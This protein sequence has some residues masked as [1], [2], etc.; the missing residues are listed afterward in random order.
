MV[1]A[2]DQQPVR[3]VLVGSGNIASGSHLPSLK[4]LEQENIC[5]VVGIADIDKDKAEATAKKFDVPVFGN[6]WRDVVKRSSA[7]AVSV[8]TTPGPN[9]SISTEAVHEN[10]HVLCEKP[11]GRNISDTRLLAEAAFENPSRITMVAFNRRY[12]PL[13]RKVV[14]ASQAIAPPSMFDGRFTRASLGAGPSD[15]LE[16]WIT[17]DGSHTIDMAISIMGMPKRIT[18]W[19]SATG[20]NVDNV[21]DIIFETMTATSHLHFNFAAGKRME[22]F[23]WIGP[24]YDVTL[25]LPLQAIWAERGKPVEVWKAEEL[26][27]VALNAWNYGFGEQ[28]RTFFNAI[29]GDGP[30]PEPNF[31]YADQFMK[32]IDVVLQ[33]SNGES[34]FFEVEPTDT[35]IPVSEQPIAIKNISSDRHN[36]LKKPTVYIK[37]PHQAQSRYLTEHNFERLRSNFILR[38]RVDDVKEHDLIESDVIITGWGDTGLT[39]AEIDKA[40]KLKAVIVIGASVKG[41]NP[42]LLLERGIKL[43]N[44]ADAIASGVAEHCLLLS[45]AGLK[46]LTQIDVKMHKGIWPPQGEEKLFSLSRLLKTAKKS[47]IARSVVWPL[48]R[49]FARSTVNRIITNSN[50]SGSGGKKQ[51]HELKGQT[52]GLIGW[53]SIARH[54]VRLLKP[55]DCHILVY[56][57]AEIDNELEEYGVQR[58]SLS[59]I[60]GSAKVISLHRGL[61]DKTKGMLGIKELNRIQPNAVLINTSR[62]AL[63]DEAALLERLSKGDIIAGLD[64]FHKEPLPTNDPIRKLKNVIL[65][66]HYLAQAPEC[67]TNAGQ[68]AVAIAIDWLQDCGEYSSIDS[69]YLSRMT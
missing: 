44:T 5:K 25:E 37:L 65:T 26:T 34:S 30:R 29:R 50:S 1:K 22:R 57:E 23:E 8:T 24:D 39:A 61:T 46:Q 67:R 14:E 17:S 38:Q 12:S 28:Y 40:I 41:V 48:V 19:R 21:W 68:Q 52:I 15:T 35:S 18:V 9:A 2:N 53:G 51:I 45:L 3:I 36:V 49:P 16:N 69:V 20:S 58:A 13:T 42:E 55:F 7:T 27:G 4:R 54:F 32:L 11:P 43:Y 66:P 62:A 6:D 56:S 63:I 31:E 10:L 33:S 64:V 60:L 59:E 47:N